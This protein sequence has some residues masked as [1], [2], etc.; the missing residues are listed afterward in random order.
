MASHDPARMSISPPRAPAP[1]RSPSGH[2]EPDRDDRGD[3]GDHE[4][5]ARP[6]LDDEAPVEHE[7]GRGAEQ[8]EHQEATDADADGTSVG[9]S[10]TGG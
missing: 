10:A 4:R 6:D 2:T 7:R 3:V 5:P 8:A 1:G 9:G